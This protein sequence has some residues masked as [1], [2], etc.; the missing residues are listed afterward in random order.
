MFV[1]LVCVDGM[2]SPAHNTCGRVQRQQKH[3]IRKR[4]DA[5][6]RKANA[7]AA[8]LKRDKHEVHPVL[9]RV[10]RNSPTCKNNLEFDGL[11]TLVNLYM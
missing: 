1:L 5:I 2:F 3:D 9:T 11:W 10:H 6:L 7:P 8:H 4:L